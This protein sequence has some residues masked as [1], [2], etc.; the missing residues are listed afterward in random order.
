MQRRPG[1]TSPEAGKP[2]PAGT[3][4]ATQPP[5]CSRVPVHGN[6]YPYCGGG[7]DQPVHG[8][9]AEVRDDN[10]EGNEN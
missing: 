2:P 5:D 10:A 4:V 6:H 9:H 8:P 3:V 1:G 7:Q